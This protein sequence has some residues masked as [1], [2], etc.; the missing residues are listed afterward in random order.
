MAPAV[1]PD[2][3]KLSYAIG[4]NI[5]N[6][7]KRSEIDVDVDTVAA[8]IKDILAGKP[9]RFSDAEYKEIFEQLNRAMA[10]RR[11][12]DAEK[13]IAFLAENAKTEGV[14]SLP[15]GV[16][17][18]V[19]QE[20]SGPMPKDNDTVNVAYR[21]TLMDGTVFDETNN[22]PT[23]VKGRLIR[24]WQEILPMMKQ[25]SKWKVFIPSVMG[26]GPRGFPPKIGPNAVL[27]FDLELKSI[28]P[29]A[30]VLPQMTPR[31][32]ASQPPGMTANTPVVSG[33]II[34]VPSADE[35]KH[36]AKIEVIE[37]G[38]TNTINSQ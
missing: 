31:A 34:K 38:K 16:Q 11:Q 8:A 27:I 12:A 22:F 21:G 25:G 35:L 23:P 1:M 17:Y 18:K 37:P 10:A 15:S 3:D 19:I 33:Q 4:M 26:Y 30:P 28:T 20:G 2:K 24:G 32:S 13:G 5:G 7:I 36:G 29:G 6:G 14:K 9:T